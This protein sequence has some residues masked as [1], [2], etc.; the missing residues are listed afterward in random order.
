MDY[1][2]GKRERRISAGLQKEAGHKAPGLNRHSGHLR[3]LEQVGADGTMG[4]ICR[5]G[6]FDTYHG[7]LGICFSVYT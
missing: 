5:Y 2:I 4:K 3:I 7:V 1:R 6:K